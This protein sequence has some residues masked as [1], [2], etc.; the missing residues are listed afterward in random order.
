MHLASV[1]EAE[2]LARRR[3]PPSLYRSIAFGSSRNQTTIE[4][5]RAFEGVKLLPRAATFHE[6]RDLRT[7]LFG[8][9]LA[10]PVLTAP[11]GATRLVHPDGALG[12][13]RAAVTTETIAVISKDCGHTVEEVV[14]AAADPARVWQQLYVNRGRSEAE[15]I[16]RRACAAGY[17]ALV[18]TVDLPVDPDSPHNWRRKNNP[19]AHPVK[20][21][22][23]NAIRFGPELVRRPTWL[24]RFLRDRM[25]LEGLFRSMASMPSTSK[26]A[27]WKDLEWIRTMWPGTIVLKGILMPEDARRAIDLGVSGI[28]VSNHGGK[29]LD[30]AIP[31]LQALPGVIAAVGGQIE[32]L[33]DGGVR[34]GIDVVRAIAMGARAVL[35]GRPYLWGLAA[36]GEEGVRAVLEVLRRDIDRTLGLLGCPSVAEL[37][38]SYVQRPSG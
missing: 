22:L 13:A 9:D 15:D 33:V 3:L 31:T 35:I 30:G 19:E 27:T 21:D 2:V 25:D 23:R 11:T 10:F 12:A 5:L 34:S 36:E 1:E 8:V 29:A 24:Y 14:A 20:L 37:D 7:S 16:I 28:V 18:V 38:L 26:I 32:V 4:N 17:G 6:T